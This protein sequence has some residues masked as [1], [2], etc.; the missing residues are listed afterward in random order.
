[1]GTLINSAKE[2]IEA[3]RKMPAL[4]GLPGALEL[5]KQLVTMGAL[6]EQF[7]CPA[8]ENNSM[9]VDLK[10][11]VAPLYWIGLFS[12]PDPDTGKD[13]EMPLAFSTPEQSPGNPVTSYTADIENIPS[14]IRVCN[15][16]ART[17]EC[18][19]RLIEYRAVS[20]WDKNV[21]MVPNTDTVN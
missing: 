21:F 19:W 1:M 20:E 17:L 10:K 2:L 5:E 18:S 16:I 9:V 14:L 11:E 15:T 6:E 13:I 3:L 7:E 8:S 12:I 4:H